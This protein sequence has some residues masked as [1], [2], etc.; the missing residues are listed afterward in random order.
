MK[1]LYLLLFQSSIVTF[2]N[3]NTFLQTEERLIYS[4]YD[5]IQTFM[6]KLASKFIK[7]NV[8]QELK[9]GKKLFFKLDI[10][11]E[12]QRNNNNLFIGF[13][14]KQ[15]LKKLLKDEISAREADRFFDGVAFYK[16][17]YEYCTKLLPLD[18]NLLKISRF[19]DFSRR[20]EFSFDE[21]QSVANALPLLNQ[22]IL[23]N[24]HKVDE[25]EEEFLAYQAMSGNKIP[26]HVWE[27][28]KF[29]ENVDDGKVYYRMGI[30]WANLST[31]LPTLANVIIQMLTISYNNAAEERVFSMINKNK[32]QLCSTLDL[33]KSLNSIMLIKMNSQEG[34]VSC[35]KVKFSEELL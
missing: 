3:F 15:T 12:Y 27:I 26:Q 14:T 13:R 9:N 8:I 20:S 2:P 5:H 19:I 6:N 29:N 7:P 17:A 16:A 30:I 25:L 33:G 32:T 1:E 11:L 21:V 34:L 31:N 35:H 24:V 22:H 18:N 28:P 10:L 23:N 4:I